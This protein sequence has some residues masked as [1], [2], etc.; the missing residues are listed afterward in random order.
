M[1]VIKCQFRYCVYLISSNLGGLGN[2]CMHAM[3]EKKIRRQ[4]EMLM[5]HSSYHEK[6][7]TEKTTESI[8]FYL[9]HGCDP[10]R[11]LL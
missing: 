4:I 7:K 10:S 11:I 3:E 5:L 1:Y 8:L 6:K 9:D 2:A